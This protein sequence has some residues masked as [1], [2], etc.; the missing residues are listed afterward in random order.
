LLWIYFHRDEGTTALLPRQ[1]V[2]PPP[3]HASTANGPVTALAADDDCGPQVSLI[4]LR[5]VFD[6]IDI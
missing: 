6:H 2:S 5:Q 1:S 3:R 4:P